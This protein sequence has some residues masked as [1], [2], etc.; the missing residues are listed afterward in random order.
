[1]SID[2][3][4]LVGSMVNDDGMDDVGEIKQEKNE[5][6]WESPALEKD[7]CGRRSATTKGVMESNNTSTT[8]SS[9]SS[10]C[11]SD[12]DLDLEEISRSSRKK[13]LK[14]TTTTTSGVG[15]NLYSNITRWLSRSSSPRGT[16]SLISEDL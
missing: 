12:M 16:K 1:M 14:T 11:S 8:I 6:P 10:Y 9:S 4:T 7:N 15:G 2:T 5:S 13:R 3:Y